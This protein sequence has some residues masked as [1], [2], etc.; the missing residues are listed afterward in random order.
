MRLLS[1]ITSFLYFLRCFSI[2]LFAS[3]NSVTPNY[4]ESP[5]SNYSFLFTTDTPFSADFDIFVQFPTN[6]N[7][8]S[9]S[10]CTILIN[11]NPLTTTL[12]TTVANKI[13]FTSLNIP[14]IIANITIQ[15]NTST[16]LYAGRSTIS[17]TFFNTSTNTIIPELNIQASIN[18][19]NAI[20][21]CQLSSNSDVVGDTAIYTLSYLPLV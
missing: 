3:T 2:S 9:V 15:F 20:M 7:I 1:I 16:S 8:T 5:S 10:T 14:S 19:N 12:C 18:I 17:F 4:A 21:N 6:F 11:S 13:S